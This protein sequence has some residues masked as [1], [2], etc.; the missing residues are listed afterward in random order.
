[1]TEDKIGRQEIVDKICSLV[2]N[3]QKDKYFCLALNGDWGSGKTF[4]MQ[5]I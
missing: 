5:M 2:D 4:V 3:L 1:M